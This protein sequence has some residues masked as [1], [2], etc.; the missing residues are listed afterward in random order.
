MRGR[1][2]RG[3]ESLDLFWNGSLCTAHGKRIAF[4]IA[5]AGPRLFC[6]WMLLFVVFPSE[7]EG[8][9]DTCNVF[10]NDRNAVINDSS[11]YITLFE[12]GT[13]RP[14]ATWDYTAR[15][16][17]ESPRPSTAANTNSES[18][19]TIS[20]VRTSLCILSFLFCFF[21]PSFILF[22]NLWK[23]SRSACWNDRDRTGETL[24]V[25]AASVSPSLRWRRK[26]TL[27]AFQIRLPSDPF[28]G[29]E[30][31]IP[32]RQKETCFSFHLEKKN[33]SYANG[34]RVT[35]T[36]S[37]VGSRNTEAAWRHRFSLSLFYFNEKEKK[38]LKDNNILI[39]ILRV[40]TYMRTWA[41]KK[42]ERVNRALSFTVYTSAD[43]SLNDQIRQ[44][45]SSVGN[46]GCD[47]W[48]KRR[49]RRKQ[50]VLKMKRENATT[51]FHLVPFLLSFRNIKNDDAMV[52]RLLPS[53]PSCNTFRR[54]LLFIPAHSCPIPLRCRKKKKKN[55][56]ASMLITSQWWEWLPSRPTAERKRII[57]DL[58][59]IIF[60]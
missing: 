19:L 7:R 33:I 22:E 10:S 2:K 45:S 16:T 5:A 37:P 56:S 38:N 51:S 26:R 59:S 29:V 25:T 20:T 23:A 12:T 40:C 24:F 6:A 15:T 21:S 41:A 17:N 57:Y 32:K 44:R 50:N 4:A 54:R 55:E 8:K 43:S 35:G 42:G 28:R 47:R 52:I 14:T 30:N 39:I 36:Q 31:A 34:A 46:L 11:L 49:R 3:G 9:K 13:R 1:V 27:S 58:V 48:I 53:S 18:A 60:F